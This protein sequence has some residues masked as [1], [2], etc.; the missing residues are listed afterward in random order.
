MLNLLVTL[1]SSALPSHIIVSSSV[2]SYIL[3]V[4]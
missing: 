4:D 1:F 3:I 2:E